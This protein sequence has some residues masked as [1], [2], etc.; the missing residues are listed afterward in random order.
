MI[1][2]ASVLFQQINMVPNDRSQQ[3]NVAV[4]SH[5]VVRETLINGIYTSN[6]EKVGT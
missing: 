1:L 5:S 3:K 4:N 6:K 2:F